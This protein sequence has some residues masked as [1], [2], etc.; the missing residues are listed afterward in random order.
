MKTIPGKVAMQRAEALTKT[1]GNF[2]LCF[3]PFSLVKPPEGDV[4]MRTYERCTMRRPLPHD[5][6]EDD[7][8]NY[9]LFETEDGKPRSCYRVLIRYIAF[10]DDGYELQKVKW[11]E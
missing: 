11:Y 3:Y 8:K 9:F 4:E 1:G 5:K 7:G 10:S 2:S 6:W